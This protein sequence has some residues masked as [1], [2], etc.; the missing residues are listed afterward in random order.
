MID[1]LD[2]AMKAREFIRLCGPSAVPVSVD[3]Y[4]AQIGGQVLKETLGENEDA[5]SFRDSAGRYR[6]CVNCTHNARRQ[7][8]SVCHEVAHVVLGIPSDH[9]AP[10]W[11]YSR[12]PPGEIACDVFAAELLLPYQQF[13]PRVDG[14]DLSIAAIGSLADEF[15]AS[16]ISTGSRFAT[17]SREICALIVS[18]GGKVRYS[19]RSARL[20]EA[21]GWI[22]PGFP[23]PTDSFSARIRAG[24]RPSGREDADPDSWFEDWARDGA[25]FEDALHLSQWDQTLTLLWFDDEGLAAPV[26]ERKQWDDDAY[27]LRELDGI[28]PWP[29]G[30]KRR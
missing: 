15:D 12:R 11:S 17:F 26:P 24:E 1:E 3:A 2:I 6:I 25:L 7:R 10:S 23:L 13:K 4:A 20:R 22:R 8:F 18:E 9:T 5:W 30:K 14:S 29:S 28:L 16:L 27:L 21:R 19:A